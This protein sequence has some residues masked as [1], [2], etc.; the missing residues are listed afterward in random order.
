M[1]TDEHMPWTKSPLGGGLRVLMKDVMSSDDDD[2]DG[3]R[4]AT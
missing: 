1:T 3:Q 4:L 2:D